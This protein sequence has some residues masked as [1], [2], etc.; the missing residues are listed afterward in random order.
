LPQESQLGAPD[1]LL[2]AF[3]TRGLLRGRLEQ[4]PDGTWV[5]YDTDIRNDVEYALAHWQGLVTCG[6][7]AALS[8]D[9]RWPEIRGRSFTQV[10]DGT[11][12]VESETVLGELR[13]VNEA[14]EQEVLDALTE[15]A[16][17][18]GLTLEAV[19]FAHLNGCL[20]PEITAATSDR[21]VAE[22]AR[23]LTWPL[24]RARVVEGTFVRV[25]SDQG[26][27]LLA[28]GDGVRLSA[29]VQNKT[30]P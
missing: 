28:R 20:A 9:R 5:V 25:I 27:C 18:A 8:R 24:L 19:R 16:D 26:A 23:A 4:R 13:D 3:P 10:L 29:A 2:R 6:V 15:S 7:L 1:R 11:R 14:S 30:L 12:R 22:K 17:Q 21:A